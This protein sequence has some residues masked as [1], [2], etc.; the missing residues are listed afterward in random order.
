MQAILLTREIFEKTLLMAPEILTFDTKNSLLS[1][2]FSIFQ[3][4]PAPR[5]ITNKRQH[6]TE[7]N[8]Q[9]HDRQQ[10]SNAKSVQVDEAKESLRIARTLSLNQYFRKGSYMYL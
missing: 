5:S 6:F 7:P 1:K 8:A 2:L 4:I 10:H 3:T 9:N